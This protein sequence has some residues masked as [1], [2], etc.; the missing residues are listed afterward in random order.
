MKMVL[1]NSLVPVFF[2]ITT[3][4]YAQV[5][6]APTLQCVSVDNNGDV[7]LNWTNPVVL[8]GPFNAYY[9]YQATNINGPYTIVASISDQSQTTHTDGVG[10]GGITTYYYFMVSDFNC[11]GYTFA[12]SDTLDNL[13]PATPE[14]NYVTVNNGLAVINWE[15]SSSPETYGYIIYRVIDTDTIG[16]DTVYGQFNTTYNDASST[17]NSNSMAYTL[18]AIDS[19]DNLGPFNGKS[20]HTIYLKDSVVRCEQKIILS[21]NFYDNWKNGIQKYDVEMSLNGAPF[22]ILQ[23]LPANVLEYTVGGFNDRD[24]VCFRITA[25]ENLLPITSVSNELC[26]MVNVVQPVKDFYIRNVTVPSPNNI[27]VYFSMDS[28]SDLSK[29]TMHR[30]LDTTAFTQLATIPPPYDFSSINVFTDTTAFTDVNSYYYRL[31]ATD[32]CGANYTSTVGKSILLKGYAF[33]DLSFYVTWDESFFDFGEVLFYDVY[34]DDGAGFNLVSSEVPEV[35]SYE[36][37]DLPTTTPCYFVI[38]VDSMNFPNGIADTVHSRS[39]IVCLNQPSEIYMPNA[40]APLGKNNSFKPILNVQGVKSYSFSVFNRWGEQLFSSTD[41]SDG[42]DG[43]YK[44]VYVQ[45]GAYA[46]IVNV[47]DDKGTRIE[48][49]GTVLVIR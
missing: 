40:F 20:Q 38:A 8:C 35:L 12:Y 37:K 30:G 32:S 26:Y 23:S 6:D 9:I 11:P 3:W 21:W 15:P 22:V 16:I 10:D 17:P 29:L 24:S 41:P 28:L 48:A 5:V 7:V 13:D 27:L 36:E 19:C 43:K 4:S 49:K 45:Q 31:I 42:W 2:M 47:I 33:T 14:I 18:A 44:S 46:Y 25:K 34:R 39:N 1:R